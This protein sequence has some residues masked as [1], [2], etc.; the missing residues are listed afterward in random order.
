MKKRAMKGIA[1]ALCAGVLLI[2]CSSE[3]Q[4]RIEETYT[5]GV[6]TKSG[7]SEY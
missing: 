4:I 3:Q 2:S 5:I 1:V 7:T 6:V